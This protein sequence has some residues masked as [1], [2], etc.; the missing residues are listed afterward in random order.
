[1]RVITPRGEE[2]KFTVRAINNSDENI[3][4]RR[5]RLNGKPYHKCHIDYADIIAGGTLELVMGNKPC[6]KW[7]E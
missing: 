5:I 7:K 6:K 4:I 3:Y 1:M 2:R